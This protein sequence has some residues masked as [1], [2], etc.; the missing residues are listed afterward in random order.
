LPVPEPRRASLWLATLGFIAVVLLCGTAATSYLRT[1]RS[2]DH[3]LEV[4]RSID[5]WRS[6]V[7]EMESRARRYVDQEASADLAQFETA[8]ARQRTTSARL[9]AL[10]ADHHEQVKNLGTA[11]SDAEAL[12]ER[13]SELTGLVDTG[14]GSEARFLLAV[15]EAEA[16]H[17]SD[18]FEE[19]AHRM[20]VIEDRLLVQRRDAA[21]QRVFLALF[22]ALVLSILAGGLLVS[23][24]YARARR[25]AELTRILDEARQRLATLS[26]LAVALSEV[27]TPR[28]VAHVVV[29][30]GRRALGADTCTLYRLDEAGTTLELIGERGVAPELVNTIRRVTAT[31][32]D[33]AAFET[34]RTGTAIWV[35][36]ETD[37]A[38][39][40]PRLAET[41]IVGPRAKAFWSVPLI[42]EG[43]PVGL[44]AMGFYTER[45]F[46]PED[47]VLVDTLSKHCAQ[48][49][50]RASRRERE[51]ETNRWFTTTLRSIGDAVIATDAEG[52]VTFM[53]PIAEALTGY[54]EEEA[55]GQP[56]DQVFSIF[57]EQTRQPM[58]SPV[59]KVL[60]EG[61]VVGL[62][63]HT[64]LRTKSGR[65]I[66]IDDSGAP[67]RA[68]DDQL[69]GVVLVFRDVSADKLVQARR[70]FMS[71]AGEALVSSLD[72]QA[73]LKTVA[74][75][76]VPVIADWCA[77]EI[78]EPGAPL[79]YQ[80]AVHHVDPK[81]IEF[82][83]E[84][85][86]RYP[87]DPM[88]PT[89]APN[90]MRTGKAEL[91]S[92]I[93]SALLEAAARDAEHL[94]LIRELEL[95][96]ALVV[97]L[98]VRGRT[99]G[100]ITLA[101][102]ESNRRY[103]EDDREFA[104]DFAR[105]AA[106]AI[107]NALA[108]RAVEAARIEEHRLRGDAEV[109]SRA[110]DEFLA[111]VSHELRTPLN[112]ILGWTVLLRAPNG[113]KNLERGLNVIER[114]AR[115][116]AK[117]IDDVL[118]VSRIISG[119][120]ALTLG[121]TNVTDAVTASIETVTPAAEAKGITIVADL[122]QRPLAITA[123]AQ[124]VQQVVWNLLSNAVKFTPKGGRVDVKAYL[125]GSDVHIE[126]R[127]TGEG[128][129]PE[130]LTS[131][132]DPF[133]QADTSTTRR[134]GG[135]GLGLAIV[136]QLVSAHGGT[137][138]AASPGLG[139]GASFLVRLPARSVVSAI[140][141]RVPSAADPLSAAEAGLPRLDGMR[142][143]VVDD[144][145]DALALV[146]E[147]LV[148]H[149]AHVDSVASA[150]E[151]LEWLESSTP[152]VIVSDIGMPGED[153]YSLIRKIR[154]LPAHRGGRTPAIALT[155][156]ARA[157]DAQRALSAGFQLHV[158][159]PVE[160]ARLAHVVADLGGR[161]QA[162]S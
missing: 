47:R 125:E 50:L 122:P 51:D 44:L 108:V 59:T 39:L 36:N 150:R 92:E 30:T 95:C 158:V 77:I 54:R 86:E 28:E 9:R 109:A 129:L 148:A 11:A 88:A 40:F 143:L 12:S 2:V 127:D 153:G 61:R 48:A 46:P 105:L 120:L 7:R 149:G 111:M 107:E 87:P 94:R 52:C 90:V 67:I 6:H 25:Q 140:N 56:L 139:Q 142:L 112:A 162:G 16:R 53:N 66:P 23:V 145:A 151:A 99:F 89:G 96:S 115:A 161:S 136:R 13:F 137:V 55:R 43:R 80:A 102:A 128:M 3:T 64:L 1:L 62:A 124:R 58:D 20:Q 32:G 15:R 93:P 10:V 131:A 104:E 133:Q 117:L 138:S 157:E 70:E 34:L 130:A 141:R 75:L 84:L 101:Y 147:V 57:S 116:Q 73:T 83:R 119:K 76:A 8:L 19:S 71:Q 79:A 123:D 121:P 60:R 91:Y 118:D 100:A 135:L 134:H 35:E 81:K 113:S 98:T 152:D 31:S 144:E 155:A 18:R 132:F 24:W 4:L 160:P 29:D 74:R 26:E 65:E 154:A 78:R 156:Y 42:V 106:M 5:D 17:T 82:V 69:V 126:V 33:P 97:P 146:T 103:S 110:K 21:K 85:G 68:E 37:Y 114:N 49:L 63:N 27:R 14:R 41:K 45:R 38:R 22:L 159:K 72:Y